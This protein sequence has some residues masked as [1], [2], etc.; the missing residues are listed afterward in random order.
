MKN[1]VSSIEYVHQ[2]PG[3]IG[4]FKHIEKAMRNCYASED[5]INAESYKKMIDT[6]IT[7]KHYSVL[8]HGTVYLTVNQEVS[9]Y[10]DIFNFYYYN[11][12][13][14]VV[15]EDT[16]LYVTTNYRVIVENERDF[17]LQYVTEPSKHERR[18][19]FRVECSE[20]IAREANRNRGFAGST[21][22]SQRSTRYCNLSK[23]KFGGVTFIVPQWIFKYAE[24]QGLDK[25][26]IKTMITSLREGYSTIDAYYNALETAEQRYLQLIAEGRRAEE[27]RGVLPLDTATV[28]YYTA[29]KEDWDHFIELRS[30]ERAHPD[31]RVLSDAINETLCELS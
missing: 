4:M 31:I 3:M 14:R 17:D 26:N 13:S 21:A 12:F 11:P 15:T 28:V 6:A 19:T 18:Y 25:K 8:E 5:R 2:M 29:Y 27:A 20:A 9:N 22:I 30:S 7:S 23:D 1:K 16:T 10:D 24:E